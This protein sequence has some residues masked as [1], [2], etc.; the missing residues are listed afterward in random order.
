MPIHVAAF[1][2]GLNVSLAKT[3]KSC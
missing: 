1:I 2:I 3:D